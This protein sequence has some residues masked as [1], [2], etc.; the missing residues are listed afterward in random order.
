MFEWIIGSYILLRAYHQLY[1]FM[2]RRRI[3]GPVKIMKGAEPFFYKRGKKAVLFL[4]G[5]STS[6]R[7]FRRMGNFLARNGITV[8][9]PLLPGHGTSPERLALIKYPQWIEFVEE[10]VKMLEKEYEEIYL[11]GDSLGGN[12]SII[13]ANKSKKIKGIITLGT[14]MLFKYEKISRYFLLPFFKRIKLFQK[15]PFSKE[16]I[17]VV[18]KKSAIYYSVPFK[19][20]VQA[21]KTID[22]S[23][24]YLPK[25]KKPV[26]SIYGKFDEK[27]VPGS[28]KYLVDELSARYIQENI[29]SK[30]KKLLGFEA[31]FHVFLLDEKSNRLNKHFLGFIN[32]K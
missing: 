1:F 5:Y 18:K 15:K 25:I 21:L 32:G 19:S 22:L 17:E 11:V 30:N 20:L 26:L 2:I 24:D 29:K 31:N 14:P 27:N 3:K 16:E 23:K 7:E 10:Q 13:T 9:A 28:A 4:H 12:L 6:P 8:Y